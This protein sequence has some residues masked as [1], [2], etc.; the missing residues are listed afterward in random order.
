REYS[1]VY[2]LWELETTK[3]S[4]IS[5]DYCKDKCHK[6]IIANCPAVGQFD[7]KIFWDIVEGKAV[8]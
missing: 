4:L 5:W 1:V 8:F 7:L 3:E 6:Y 2:S